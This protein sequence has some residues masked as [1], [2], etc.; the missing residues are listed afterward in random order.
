MTSAE[1]SDLPCF[2]A[3]SYLVLLKGTPGS[4]T[5]SADF[6]LVALLALKP[7]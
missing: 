5:L 7:Y 4:K 1:Y 2:S 3:G 6:P